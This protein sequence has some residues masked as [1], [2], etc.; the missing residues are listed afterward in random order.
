M[1]ALTPISLIINELDSLLVLFLLLAAWAFTLAA[2]TGSLRRPVL[3]AFVTGLA[4]N[5]KMLAA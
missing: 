3:G 5:V 1:L 2:E 4:F